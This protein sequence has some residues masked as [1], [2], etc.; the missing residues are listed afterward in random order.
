MKKS[1]VYNAIIYPPI[2]NYNA[3][4]SK[5]LTIWMAMLTLTGVMQVL[6]SSCEKENQ[7]PSCQITSPVEGSEFIIG[8]TITIS[9]AAEDSDGE[10]AEI[11]FYINDIGIS[12]ATSFPYNYDWN[13]SEEEEGI[14]KIK[15]TAKDD[16]G[17]VVEDEISILLTGTFSDPRDGKIYTT[18]P[19]GTQTWMAENLAYLPSVVGSGTGSQT[20]SYHY[21][22]G[23]NGISV[24]DAKATSNYQTYGVLY[25]W[26]AALQ[27]CPAGWHLP[28]DAE[29]KE[30]EM[31]LGMSKTE[32]DDTGWRGTDE[33][34]K[35]KETGTTHWNSPNT[36]ATN[37]S[38][39][40][41]LPGG[42]RYGVIGGDFDDFGAGGY[43]WSATEYGTTAA[44]SR[45]MLY[46]YSSVN[47]SGDYKEYGVSV[48]C[49][50]DY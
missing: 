42:Y 49:V 44:W 4:K 9:A 26:P 22:Y 11:R 12:S 7:P 8:E 3:M 48:R 17:A 38:G 18:V 6:I 32:A 41:A 29:W 24:T 13:T 27:A 2:T 19:I 45:G 40:T 35:L 50:L 46:G 39:F 1:P 15:V 33:G 30:L 23:Y 36:G 34:G 21:V 37:E 47:R 10:I 20:T 43:W 28:S 5:T 16:Q 25:N 14:I 31:Y